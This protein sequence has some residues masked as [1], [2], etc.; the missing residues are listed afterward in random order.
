MN[1][2]ILHALYWS[3]DLD[4]KTYTLRRIK[5]GLQEGQFNFYEVLNPLAVDRSDE[6]RWTWDISRHSKVV[7]FGWRDHTIS[8]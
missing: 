4:A 5:F 8:S 3:S 6:F 2:E 7:T 1:F